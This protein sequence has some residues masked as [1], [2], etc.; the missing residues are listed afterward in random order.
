MQSTRWF[1]LG[2]AFAFAFSMAVAAK[3]EVLV[4]SGAPGAAGEVVLRNPFGVLRSGDGALWWCEYDGHV[5]RRMDTA[6]K[7]T[8]VAG[9]GEAGFSGDGGDA[10]AARLNQPHEIRLDREGHLYFTD[11]KNHAIRR[12]DRSTGRISTIAGT[13]SPGYSGD[14]GAA[15]GATLRQ[16]HSLQ[17]DSAGNLFIG[18]TGNHVVRKIDRV[19]GVITTVAGTGK[20]GPTPDSGPLAGV[21]LNGPRA[22]DFDSRGVMWLATREGNQLFRVDLGAGRIQRVAGTGQKGPAGDAGPALAARLTGPKG[23]AV[24]LGA[25]GQVAGVILVDTESHLLRRV[26]V[27]VGSI[28]RILGTGLKAGGFSTDPLQCPL[29][30]P[31]GVWIEAGGALLVGDS[32]NHRILR[33]VP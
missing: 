21:P 24:E 20:P 7:V 30:R 16:P 15:S 19:T 27:R 12:V 4:G 28:D 10:T 31:H 29:A 32:E 6:G 18:D 17:F 1:G 33:V 14:G 26:D 5:I 8:L 22:I 3:V 23:V 11:M 13:G 2:A 25:D 9:C